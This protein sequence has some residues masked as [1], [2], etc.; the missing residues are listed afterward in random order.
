M[1]STFNLNM[2][3]VYTKPLNLIK[4]YIEYDGNDFDYINSMAVDKYDIFARLVESIHYSYDG[5][6]KY[7]ITIPVEKN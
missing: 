7:E 2:K 4:L 3:M 6:N 1:P 5:I